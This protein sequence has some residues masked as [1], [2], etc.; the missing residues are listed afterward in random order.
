MKKS[1]RKSKKS[2]KKSKKNVRTSFKPILSKVYSPNGNIT[3][4]VGNYDREP[5][6]RKMFYSPTNPSENQRKVILTETEIAKIL[7]EKPHPNIV[8]YF[9]VTPE[10]VDM[11]QLTTIEYIEKDDLE[12]LVTIMRK[13]KTFLQELG[14]VYID[15]KLG[16]IGKDK[17]GNYKL[18]DFDVSGIFNNTEWLLEPVH[19]Y[20]Y[21]YAIKQGATTP[22]DIDNVCFEKFIDDLQ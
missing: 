17:H 15:W 9:K 6:F 2:N 3:N 5:F 10:Y 7:M 11:E 4:I 21:K 16:N 1:H 13:V 8:R 14:I 19:Y 18:F 22:L 12:I 20:N